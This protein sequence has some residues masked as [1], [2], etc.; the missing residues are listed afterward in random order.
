MIDDN[1]ISHKKLVRNVA[2][3]A[4]AAAIGL[5][6]AFQGWRSRIPDAQDWVFDA[7]SALDLVQHGRIPHHGTITSYFSYAPPGEAWLYAPGILLFR[8]P[9]LAQLPVHALLYL[10][11]LAGIFLLARRY[12]GQS[13]AFLATTA[14]ALSMPAV[15]LTLSSPRGQ[16]FFY[17]AMVYCICRWVEE[18]D[19]RFLAGALLAWTT[20]ML[21]FLE[22]A[23][24]IFIV[25]VVWLLWRPP[26]RIRP[27][28]WTGAL[29]LLL[30]FPYLHFE[31]RRHFADIRS[32]VQLKLLTQPREDLKAWCGPNLVP[33]PI[34]PADDGGAALGLQHRINTRLAIMG[35]G[36]GS[37][38]KGIVPGLNL[39][40][41]PMTLAGLWL[42]LGA[43]R[44][45]TSTRASTGFSLSLALLF[46]AFLVHGLHTSSHSSSFL[47]RE[48][49]S[50]L[51][52]LL[53]GSPQIMLLGFLFL[54][55]TGILFGTRKRIGTILGTWAVQFDSRD[56]PKPLALA[57]LIP[58]ITLLCVAERF[59]PD[60]F[61]WLGALQVVVLAVAISAVPRRGHFRWVGPAALVVLIAANPVLTKRITAWYQTGWSGTDAPESQLADYLATKI[62]A[63]GE[64]SSRIGYPVPMIAGH[65]QNDVGLTDGASIDLLLKFKG[66]ANVSECAEGISPNDQFR[67]VDRTTFEPYLDVPPTEHFR[68]DRRFGSL[69]VYE[70]N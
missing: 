67:V 42:C 50:R 59:R 9:R 27:L 61:Q 69:E 49:Q 14:Y 70:R 8:D 57:L 65:P 51:P 47:G 68:L 1:V 62:H 7:T 20:G 17:V 32:Q 26:V 24:A 41:I 39:I 21:V 3:L 64:N 40:L 58:W 25:P 23:P 29:V 15:N 38:F 45:Q 6:L 31:V 36:L 53:S 48:F 28:I 35:N 54:G 46:A 5:A 56:N 10:G 34:A 4:L 22:L 63:A 18:M 66:V 44:P 13:V 37:N 30:W 33:A 11:T 55:I 43:W 52:W 16:P 12:L 60:R 19:G 2:V